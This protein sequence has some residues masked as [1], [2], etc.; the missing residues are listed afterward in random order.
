MCIAKLGDYESFD[1]T[2][3]I[4][5]DIEVSN[6]QHLIQFMKNHKFTKTLYAPLHTPE[7]L[8]KGNFFK[9]IFFSAERKVLKEIIFSGNIKFNQNSSSWLNFIGASTVGNEKFLSFLQM[10]VVCE[11]GSVWDVILSCGIEKNIF[12]RGKNLVKHCAIM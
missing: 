1:I 11:L 10:H 2:T 5:I 8:K 12:S 7:H 4:E 6:L 9:A 3:K